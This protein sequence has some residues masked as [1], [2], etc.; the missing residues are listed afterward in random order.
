MYAHEI[1]Q[2]RARNNH[3]NINIFFIC[4]SGDYILEK[5]EKTQFFP[6]KKER[7]L[8]AR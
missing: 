7:W 8:E 4:K 6:L 5:K 2:N 3:T 1:C